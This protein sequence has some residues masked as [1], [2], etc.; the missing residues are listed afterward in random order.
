MTKFSP[1]D[2]QAEIMALAATGQNLK[3]PALAGCGKTTLLKMI[4]E[5]SPGKQY[6]YLVFNS[7]MQKKANM[8]PNV[9]ARTGNSLAWNFM[10][11]IYKQ[12]GLD[13]PKRFKGLSG[14]LVTNTDLS[15]YF[16]IGRYA[17]IETKKVRTSSGRYELVDQ[18]RIISGAQAISHLKKA[19]TKF[20]I[21]ED[22]E[23][24][25]LHFPENISYPPEAVEDARKL[26]M[27]LVSP[28]GVQ[29]ITFDAT[30][31]I[32][33]LSRPDISFSDKDP[34]VRYSALLLDEAQD[35]NP[36]FA[37]V[38]REQNTIQKIYV[39]D[40]NQAIYGFRGAHDE[41]DKVEIELELP[42]TKTWRFGENL[43]Q[44]PNAFL[45]A[46]GSKKFIVSGK[47]SHGVVI[48]S[49]TMTNP[50]AIICRTNAGVIR[51][52][53]ER[54]DSGQKVAVPADYVKGLVSLLKTIGWFYGYDSKKPTSI[55]ADLEEY[56]TRAEIEQAIDEGELSGKITSLVRLIDTR[57]YSDL[58]KR[59]G[60]VNALGKKD[61]I[62]IVTAHASKGREWERV[63]IYD[64]FWG[65]TYD[66]SKS[67]YVLP[68][69]EELNLAYVA[70]S[71]AME[72]IDLGSLDYILKEPPNS[73]PSTVSRPSTE[74]TEVVT[75]RL[76]LP[77]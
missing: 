40:T 58:L 67:L 33:A 72:E 38:Y 76:A 21:S 43:I 59:L 20:C 12:L 2:E 18:E 48:P 28:N 56:A 65:W 51:A 74:V 14:Q 68:P 77:K 69:D 31:K 53:F 5:A 6:R 3:V 35:T 42:L 15:R 25:I 32:W 45:E 37:R 13:M 17:I 23:I 75:T 71:R 34:T 22:D 7:D 11:E 39:G 29:K 63:Q 41:L 24:S 46:L 73:Y 64:D 49:G 26:W 4:A 47:E 70:S 10:L 54:L 9:S 30:V 57:G 19:V 16:N 8:G 44:A 36:V 52:I 60:E 62:E 61:V 50:N 55:H 27:D 1:S 66:Y